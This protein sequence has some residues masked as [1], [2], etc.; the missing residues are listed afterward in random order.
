[1]DGIKTR[2]ETHGSRTSLP[3]PLPLP[4]AIPSSF[5]STPAETAL[6]PAPVST[7][8][9]RVVEGLFRSFLQV[10]A[11]TRVRHRLQNGQIL[12][13][14][15]VGTYFSTSR[16]HALTTPCPALQDPSLRREAA[17]TRLVQGAMRGHSRIR[18]PT[19]LTSLRTIGVRRVDP[20]GATNTL[21]RALNSSDAC[22]VRAS[23][24]VLHTR[25]SFEPPARCEGPRHAVAM[26]GRGRIAGVAPWA[27]RERRY[28]LS[29]FIVTRESSVDIAVPY[30]STHG[31][32]SSSGGPRTLAVGIAA[33]SSEVGRA[34]RGRAQ[35]L[36][37]LPAAAAS[38]RL[39]ECRA[40]GRLCGL[41]ASAARELAGTGAGRLA[42]QGRQAW[43]F[44]LPRPTVRR[45]GCP[46]SPAAALQSALPGRGPVAGHV[47]AREPRRD[48]PDPRRAAVLARIPVWQPLTSL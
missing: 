30:V 3:S 25:C 1:M 37:C 43:L 4:L 42:R 8:S 36:G 34:G 31:G 39:L 41:V 29:M 10:R 21:A 20:A 2:R 48:R 18:V 13:A 45:H 6:R 32:V 38:G 7:R 33:M 17:R 24:Y 5:V 16:A 22:A 47:S 11:C 28:V 44:C 26:E 35:L 12:G 23:S 40:R 9:P 15:C 27:H 14:R 19:F 46:T